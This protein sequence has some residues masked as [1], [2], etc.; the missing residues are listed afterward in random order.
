MTG[1]ASTDDLVVIHCNG[2]HPTAGRR[3]AGVAL[4]AGENV[5]TGFIRLAGSDNAIVA[6]L[7]GA[8]R[9]VVINRGSRHPGGGHVTGV[10]DI[11]GENVRVALA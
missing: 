4:I 11:T 7:A 9:F 2:R 5:S 1:L 6:A 3:M 10:A 8:Q